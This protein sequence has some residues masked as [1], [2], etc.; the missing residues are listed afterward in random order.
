MGGVD[1]Q[2]G[3]GVFCVDVCQFDLQV[4]YVLLEKMKFVGFVIVDFVGGMQCVVFDLVGG[5][6]CV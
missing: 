5:D 6:M 1:V 4:L 3:Y 2:K